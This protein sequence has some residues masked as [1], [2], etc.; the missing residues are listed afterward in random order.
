MKAVS[1]CI[2]SWLPFSLTNFYKENVLASSVGQPLICDFG[3]S[4]LASH[5]ETLRRSTSN[6]RGL[7]GSLRWMAPE[8]FEFFFSEDDGTEPEH[9]ELT[10]VWAFGMTI[11]V[12][13]EVIHCDMSLKAKTTIGIVN[14]RNALCSHKAWSKSDAYR[15]FMESTS[16]TQGST[17]ISAE[18]PMFM[19]YLRRMLASFWQASTNVTDL[20]FPTCK[21]YNK[22]V[23]SHTYIHQVVS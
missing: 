10:D 22:G 8:F 9:S 16:Y 13:S 14:R 21:W 19:E 6:S 7:Q 12:R 17:I 23:S 5:S 4:R 2:Y 20:Q 18:T 11:L 3:I 1:K 15:G